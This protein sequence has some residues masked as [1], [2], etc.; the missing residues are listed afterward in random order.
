MNIEGDLYSL[1][2]EQY[3]DDEIDQNSC[4]NESEISEKLD[5]ES[6]KVP[7]SVNS[8]PLSGIGSVSP[9]SIKLD[10]VLSICR[11]LSHSV[12]FLTIEVHDLQCKLEYLTSQITSVETPITVNPNK[13][14][15]RSDNVRSSLSPIPSKL[16]KVVTSRPLNTTTTDTTVPYN[17]HAQVYSATF[18]GILNTIQRKVESLAEVPFPGSLVSSM[19]MLTKIL[20]AIESHVDEVNLHNTLHNS[21]LME[22][23]KRKSKQYIL[24]IS[25]HTIAGLRD[26]AQFRDYYR[27]MC[28]VLPYL[29]KVGELLPPPSSDVLTLISDSIVDDDCNFDIDIS[30]VTVRLQNE[31]EKIV[32]TIPHNCI[33]EYV[34][35]RISDVPLHEAYER[36]ISKSKIRSSLTSRDIT[37]TSQ[38]MVHQLIPKFELEPE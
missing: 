33:K 26:T 1:M 17:N 6:H 12:S 37:T 13:S 25:G 9:N 34:T 30:K 21:K 28:T 20:Q 24:P 3:N 32:S 31:T 8:Y 16:A 35:L 11:A 15:T 36:A 7:E 10:E 14:V 27:T 2:M 29:R 18:I 4:Y 22:V 38:R 19:N 23:L 5:L